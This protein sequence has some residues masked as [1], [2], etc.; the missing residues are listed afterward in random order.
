MKGH[1]LANAAVPSTCGILPQDK[2]ETDVCS[3][4]MTW[5]EAATFLWFVFQRKKAKGREERA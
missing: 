1:Y 2:E 4:Y 5:P 3:F